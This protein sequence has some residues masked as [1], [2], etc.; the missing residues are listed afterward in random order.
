MKCPLIDVEHV[1]DNGRNEKPN[2]YIV[3]GSVMVGKSS[4]GHQVVNLRKP[5]G[6][7]DQND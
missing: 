7:S 2:S 4:G 5:V 1:P 6:S 3:F